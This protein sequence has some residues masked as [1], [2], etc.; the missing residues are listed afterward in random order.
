LLKKEIVFRL[1]AQLRPAFR[2]PTDTFQLIPDTEV[3]SVGTCIV[4]TGEMDATRL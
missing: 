1:E 2:L 4:V 3:K